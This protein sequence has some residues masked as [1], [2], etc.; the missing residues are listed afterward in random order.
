MILAFFVP[1]TLFAFLLIT[2]KKLARAQLV[3]D[4]GQPSRAGSDEGKGSD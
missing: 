3:F 2:K 4:A 1:V